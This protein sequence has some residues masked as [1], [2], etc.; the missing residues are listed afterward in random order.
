MI[1][2]NCY[3]FFSF[4]REP[5]SSLCLKDPQEMRLSASP[6]YRTRRWN[7]R[8]VRVKSTW[9]LPLYNDIIG[10]FIVNFIS[11]LFRLSNLSASIDFPTSILVNITFHFINIA[12]KKLCF[13]FQV[14]FISFSSCDLWHGDVKNERGEKRAQCCCTVDNFECLETKTRKIIL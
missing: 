10:F 12:K 9:L 6:S 5:T 11:S 13:H 1:I 3:N 8:L 4:P 2:S 7:L 14:K